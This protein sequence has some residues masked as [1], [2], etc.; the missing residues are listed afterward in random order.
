MSMS[1]KFTV[2]R[3]GVEILE[4]IS[5]YLGKP[6]SPHEGAM[7]EQIG[8]LRKFR[9]ETTD[10]LNFIFGL[11]EW[12]AARPEVSPIEMLDGLS[13]YER[14]EQAGRWSL[15]PLENGQWLGEINVMRYNDGKD[16]QTLAGPTDKELEE[17]VGGDAR[18][19]FQS[20]GCIGYGTRTDLVGDTSRSR[21]KL[22][23]LVKAGD[24][25]ALAACFA[26]TRVMAV[27]FDLG[28]AE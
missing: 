8:Q 12:P 22:A 14:L 11:I 26:A 15:I 17:L 18:E 6:V 23:V 5:T 1:T 20:V 9:I 28:R 16:R 13:K 3:C 4:G 27:M 7:P 24:V 2:N 25:H 19:F 21:N 10:G